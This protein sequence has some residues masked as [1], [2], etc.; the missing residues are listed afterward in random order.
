MSTSG[1]G[2]DPSPPS[3]FIASS[4]GTG[5][6]VDQTRK[7]SPKNVVDWSPKK[8]RQASAT[9]TTSLISEAPTDASPLKVVQNDAYLKLHRAKMISRGV[10]I[11][12]YLIAAAL[13]GVVIWQLVVRGSERHVYAWA[14]GA[15]F[16]AIAVPLSLHDIYLHL[17]H[18]VRPDLQRYYIRIILMVPIY[19]IESWLAL[20]FKEQEIIFAT[21]REA[22]EAF[23][24]YSF[25]QLL[26]QFFG[27]KE[28]LL[29]IL[30]SHGTHAHMLPPLSWCIRP[31]KLTG[32]FVYRVR[33]GTFQYVITRLFFAILTL[34]L[35]YLG[36]YDFHH[37]YTA[38]IIVVFTLNLSQL[39]AMYALLMFYHE[40]Y[41]EL[42]P[43][44]PLGK[45]LSVKLV[46]FFSF[47]QGVLIS[48][49]V[50]AK[51]ITPTLDY[52]T[53]DIA[54]GIQNFLICIEMAIAAL[55]H[56]FIFSYKDFKE[57]LDAYKSGDLSKAP[58]PMMI[59]LRDLSPMD[60]VRDAHNHVTS[61]FGLNKRSKKSPKADASPIATSESNEPPVTSVEPDA[62]AIESSSSSPSDVE[63]Q[64]V[65]SSPQSDAFKDDS[66]NANT[67]TSDTSENNKP[68]VVSPGRTFS[69]KTRYET[70]NS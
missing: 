47:W 19:S 32:Q 17:I 2:T 63:A 22:Y 8:F 70:N 10:L 34:I 28:N 49:L 36:W 45:F 44:K 62:Q 42:Q 29:Q 4:S 11:G 38:R 68:L 1:G 64:E 48:L 53:D 58:Q 61:G 46:V 52:T 55:A 41:K 59:A 6:D 66:A 56:T 25:T 65:S 21:L 54:A 16:V 51:V 3:L 5:I 69:R 39:Y 18:Y 31:W 60:V 24:I 9:L 50:E 43:L 35:G 26:M 40:L 14:I 7:T 30:A 27:P 67:A 12:L 20:R 57:D 13:A 23:V 37:W 15:I 33:L